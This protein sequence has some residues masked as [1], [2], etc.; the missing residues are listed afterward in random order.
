MVRPSVIT[1]HSHRDFGVQ[2]LTKQVTRFFFVLVFGVVF[3][4]LF[5]FSIIICRLEFREDNSS[6][7]ISVFTLLHF[8]V[9]GS[10]LFVFVLCV[11]VGVGGSV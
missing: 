4:C 9:L 5:C 1:V 8:P 7:V 3:V 6:P 2:E 11:G 10:V